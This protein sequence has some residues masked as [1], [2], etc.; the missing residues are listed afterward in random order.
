LPEFRQGRKPS[1]KGEVFNH[2]HSSL[3]NVIERAFGVLKIKWRILLHITSYP[4]LKQT[5][6]IVACMAL[7]NWIRESNLHDKEFYKC[8]QNENYMPGNIQPEPSVPLPGVQLGVEHGDMHV[9]R[10]NIADGLMGDV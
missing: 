5:R 7:H 10:E 1:E 6:I 8:D 9:I 2:S 4:I 3:R